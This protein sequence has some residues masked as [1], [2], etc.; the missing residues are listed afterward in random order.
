MLACYSDYAPGGG[1]QFER[2]KLWLFVT[3][4]IILRHIHI[5][6]ENF[7]EFPQVLQKI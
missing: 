5:F 6:S 4:N 7:I 2:V 3:F 1:G